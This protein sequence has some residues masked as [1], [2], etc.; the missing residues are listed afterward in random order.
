[1]LGSPPSIPKL[2]V[3][4][5][6]AAVVELVANA[7]GM[8]P[9]ATSPVAR[10]TR[11]ERLFRRMTDRFDSATTNPAAGWPRTC[12]PERVKLLAAAAVLAVSASVGACAGSGG[13][14]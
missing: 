1:M 6:G 4:Y 2:C 10:T 9:A 14:A 12:E 11:A 8:T 7:A 3:A 5:F 13:A